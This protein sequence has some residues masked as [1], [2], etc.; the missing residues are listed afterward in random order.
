MSKKYSLYIALMVVFID[1]MGVGLVFPLFS[2]LL[3]NENSSLLSVDTSQEMRGLLFGLLVALAPLA[4]FFS[5]PLWGAYSDNQGRR[6]PLL[7]S[8]AVMFLGYVVTILSMHFSSI[9]GILF[10]RLIVGAAAGNIAISQAT[11]AD[12]STPENKA[13]HYGLLGMAQGTGFAIGPFLGGSL[14][15]Y[16]FVVP[17]IFAAVLTAINGILAFYLFKETHS[18]EGK[19]KISLKM[20][21]EQL[22]KAIRFKG[23]RTLLFSAFLHN[24]A[25]T[26]FFEFVPIHLI[27]NLSYG[28]KEVGIFFAIFAASYAISAGILIRP[29]VS[30]FTPYMLC[31]GGN[32]F[33]GLAIF[34]MPSVGADMMWIYI[35]IISFFIA[36]VT[37]TLTTL[38]SNSVS[39]QIQGEVLG[40]LSAVNAFALIT[41]PLF[42]GAIIGNYPLLSMIVG[43][44]LLVL[45]ALILL[46]VFRNKL[47]RQ[48]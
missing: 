37:P 38:V 43:G 28:P 16:G 20:G 46:V 4:H 42:S 41:S 47:L 40:I 6:N 5:A 7:K 26:F 24:F 33:G 32:L 3:F 11:I 2:S 39:N 19:K 31:L 8:I 30:R 14:S 27:K 34:F 36:F 1:L 44:S 10:S 22:S 23:L 45:T 21:L 29:F 12:V 15:G 48:S 18:M 35:C 9:A 25:W 13:K 17:F